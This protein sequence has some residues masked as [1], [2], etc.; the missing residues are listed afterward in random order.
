[1]KDERFLHGKSKKAPLLWRGVWGEALILNRLSYLRGVPIRQTARWLGKPRPTAASRND[2]FSFKCCFGNFSR[3]LVTDV[4][5]KRG[6]QHQG[7][8]QVLFNAFVVWF[9][10][11]RAMV[12]KRYTGIAN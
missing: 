10:A 11:N 12:V 2:L 3:V 9:D 7:I 4:R 1:M 5:V 6:N 8:F